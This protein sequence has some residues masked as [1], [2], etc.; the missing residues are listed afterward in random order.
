M[1]RDPFELLVS[2]ALA[3]EA[4][5]TTNAPVHLA[6]PAVRGARHRRQRRRLAWTAGVA[7]ATSLAG[8]LVAAWPGDSPRPQAPTPLGQVSATAVPD[9]AQRALDV[10]ADAVA[11]LVGPRDKI[12]RRLGIISERFREVVFTGGTTVSALVSVTSDAT[13]ETLVQSAPGAAV[14]AWPTGTRWAQVIGRDRSDNVY[15]LTTAGLLAQIT[16]DPSLPTSPTP[17]AG[18]VLE[19]ARAADSPL[20]R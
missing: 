19:A 15:F 9:P 18:S 5:R 14:R 4:R 1:N 12:G 20:Q 13:L 16:V 8:G 7:V 11:P 10:L 2:D 17:S 3:D 6:G